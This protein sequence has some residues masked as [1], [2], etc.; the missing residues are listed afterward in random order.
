MKWITR[1]Q[2]DADVAG[3]TWLIKHFLD[4]NVEFIF[5][6]A[7][8][9][10]AEATR[11]GATPFAVQTQGCSFEAIIRQHDLTADPALVLLGKIINGTVADQT[12]QAESA[13]LRAVAQGFQY[14]GLKT[15]DEIVRASWLVYNALYGYCIH[16]IV[17]G[18][19][20]GMFI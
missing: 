9:V 4:K 10:M 7:E 3:C 20:D 5:V 2:I 19:P 13:G 1:T 15:E 12:V 6:D 18:K 17:Q 11:L 14:L 16:S 8:Q